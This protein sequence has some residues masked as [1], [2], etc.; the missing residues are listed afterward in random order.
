MRREL[1]SPAA[2]PYLEAP[3]LVFKRGTKI[4]ARTDQPLVD[5]ATG[6][7]THCKAIHKIEELDNESFVRV[8]ADGVAATYEL[9]KTGHRVFQLVLDQ[10]QRTP[11]TRGYADSVDLYWFGNGIE[12]RDVGMSEKTFSRGLKELLQNAFIHP[13]TNSSYW[14]NPALFFKGSRVMFVKEYRLKQR[15]HTS[16][17]QKISEPRRDPLTVDFINNAT[18]NEASK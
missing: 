4:V 7:V 5:P 1:M 9:S 14:V 10:Y 12:G 16:Q 17:P 6:E 8:F 2:N 3:T 13:R 15:N 11:M 18:D